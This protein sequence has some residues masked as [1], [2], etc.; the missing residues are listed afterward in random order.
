MGDYVV[1][2]AP[3]WS[4][5]YSIYFFVIGL[6]AALFFFST[7]SWFRAEFGV[8][9]S[10]TFYL[11]FILLVVG[12]L[13]LIG[14][15]SQPLR[16]I[17]TLNPMFWNMTSPLMWG[18]ILLVLF[19]AASSLYFLA[20]RAGNEK[21]ARTWGVLGS[22]VALGL[23]IYTG[24]DLSVHQH[25]PIWNTPLMPV[26]FVALS[27]LSGAAVASFLAKGQAELLGVLRKLMLWS[28]GATAVMLLSLVVTTAYGGSAEE[29]TYLF[30]TTGTLGLVFI[31]LG[32]IAGT[33]VPII[34]LLA[35]LGRQQTGLWL[36]AALLLLGGM[37]LRYSILVGPQIVQT[38]YS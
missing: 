26:L 25:R 33:A 6:S 2:H 38:F 15:L 11:S 10:S 5:T 7:L 27:L 8:L 30:M 22:I 34:L 21:G 12:G 35:P 36:A 20:L 37:A 23:P 32:V 9:R 28:A 1:F 24:F 29:L 16:F 4:A 19:G 3:A 14:D 31:G 18:S 17:Y 13:L